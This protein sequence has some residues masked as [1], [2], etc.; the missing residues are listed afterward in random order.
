MAHKQHTSYR[1]N[2]DHHGKV[3]PHGSNFVSK[4][5]RRLCKF[6][7]VEDAKQ[8]FT[9]TVPLEISSQT[10]QVEGIRVKTISI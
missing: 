5:M 9:R 1:K 7:K 6:P 10:P 4:F 8:L 2:G 3:N